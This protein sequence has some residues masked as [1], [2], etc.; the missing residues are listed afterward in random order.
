MGEITPE[1]LGVGYIIS[2]AYLRYFGSWFCIGL[3]GD[4]SIAGNTR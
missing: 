2:A 4:N 1:Y 3:V